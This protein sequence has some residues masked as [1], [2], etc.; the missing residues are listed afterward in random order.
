LQNISRLADATF[1]RAQKYADEL[2]HGNVSDIRFD[3]LVSSMEKNP[4]Y[5]DIRQ[6]TEGIDKFISQFFQPKDK[7]NPKIVEAALIWA[8]GKN[9]KNAV[10]KA[11]AGMER[12]K[13]IVKPAVS[14]ATPAPKGG[15]LTVAAMSPEQRHIA[16]QTFRDKPKEVAWAEYCKLM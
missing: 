13:I 4:A 7:S 15:K 12:N 6:Y 1:A 9:M 5:R 3:S 2:V 16:E 8:R 11:A 10:K 14:G